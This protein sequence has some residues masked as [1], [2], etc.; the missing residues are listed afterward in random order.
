MGS[1]V[2]FG[3]AEVELE[4]LNTFLTLTVNALFRIPFS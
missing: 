2:K 4:A 3:T 1:L